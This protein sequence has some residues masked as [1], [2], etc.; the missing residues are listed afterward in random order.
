MEEPNM[1]YVAMVARDVQ[2]DLAA[3]TN[4]GSSWLCFLDFE[5]SKHQIL[6]IF[7]SD[8]F[9]L[10]LHDLYVVLALR[11]FTSRSTAKHV[12]IELFCDCL[13]K[14]YTR[15]IKLCPTQKEIVWLAEMM[16]DS[17]KNP[18]FRSK[19]RNIEMILQ[20]IP[21]LLFANINEFFLDLKENIP[22]KY[23]ELREFFL[24]H[25]DYK[26]TLDL[27]GVIP[28]RKYEAYDYVLRITKYETFCSL[29]SKNTCNLSDFT[30]E[31][32]AMKREIMLFAPSFKSQRD[33]LLKLNSMFFKQYENISIDEISESITRR[34]TSIYTYIER[35]LYFAITTYVRNKAKKKA[36]Q[37]LK[38]PKRQRQKHNM[39]CPDLV[40]SLILDFL[41]SHK[42]NGNGK[43]R[44]VIVC[45][46]TENLRNILAIT[47]FAAS[48]IVNS[49][50]NKISFG[51]TSIFKYF[52]VNHIVF[53]TSRTSTILDVP[54]PLL[55]P[56]QC[57]YTT[58]STI[59]KTTTNVSNTNVSKE[60][61]FMFS[62][63]KSVRRA[64]KI[65]RGEFRLVINVDE[66]FTEEFFSCVEERRKSA[67]AVSAFD[68]ICLYTKETNRILRAGNLKDVL[69]LCTAE[70]VIFGDNL[71]NR[72]LHGSK[73]SDSWKSWDF[74]WF[75]QIMCSLPFVNVLEF[76][77][78]RPRQ[79][80]HNDHWDV[81]EHVRY[82]GQQIRTVDLTRIKKSCQ[83]AKN[84]ILRNVEEHK[85]ISILHQNRVLTIATLDLRI[86]SHNRNCPPLKSS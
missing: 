15:K 51:A 20:S 68:V 78:T 84:I 74:V 56:T 5:K 53:D 23:T 72:I 41:I 59:D 3:R 12:V 62:F 82:Y 47:K 46:D 63:L 29:V 9:S 73:K 31:K 52:L 67:E 48:F 44:N 11:L 36:L 76:D 69:C 24:N 6:K 80:W 32:K 66:S 34:H 28:T 57:L 81:L 71:A 79:T 58:F 37:I 21:I 45:E 83:T 75:K 86:I 27:L 38:A 30:L 35:C 60:I 77:L 43:G 26:D 16:R 8:D 2:I 85:P 55:Y 40:S 1:R 4:L 70:R 50:E 54:T 25:K 33:V 17:S 61:V 13:S 14:C 65:K 49:S 18:D 7:Q 42:N 19:K 64:L 10:L 22:E 39:I